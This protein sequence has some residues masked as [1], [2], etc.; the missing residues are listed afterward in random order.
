MRTADF[1]A[2]LTTGARIEVAQMSATYGYGPA[3]VMPL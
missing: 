1:P 2:G 3:L